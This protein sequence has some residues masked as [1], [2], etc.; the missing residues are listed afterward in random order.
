[1]GW[2][3]CTVCT[4]AFLS[5]AVQYLTEVCA[6]YVC[7]VI[8]VSSVLIKRVSGLESVDDSTS[9]MASALR[10]LSIR[11][12]LVSSDRESVLSPALPPVCWKTLGK[13]LSTHFLI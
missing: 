11:T 6:E 10:F 5:H 2:V 3:D 13:M 7:I 4:L 9:S 1:M 12:Q 8:A